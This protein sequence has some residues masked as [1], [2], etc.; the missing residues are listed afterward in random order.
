MSGKPSNATTNTNVYV[1]TYSSGEFEARRGEILNLFAKV[2]KDQPLR[3]PSVLVSTVRR[4]TTRE[5]RA[6]IL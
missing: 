3:A 2:K 6:E 1:S 4:Q 5:K